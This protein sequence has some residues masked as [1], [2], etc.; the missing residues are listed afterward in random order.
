MT[1]YLILK[2]QKQA[3]VFSKIIRIILS[4]EFSLNLHNRLILLAQIYDFM[5]QI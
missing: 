1:L 4:T 2:T 3:T 5:T